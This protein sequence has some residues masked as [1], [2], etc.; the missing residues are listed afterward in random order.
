MKKNFALLALSFGLLC[1][2][3]NL[4]N[5]VAG[6]LQVDFD[7]TTPIA[8]NWDD[9][10]ATKTF[11]LTC[12]MPWMVVKDAAFPSWIEVSP[13]NDTGSATV[14]I[15]ITEDNPFTILR[16]A[17]ITFLSINNDKVEI[18]VTQEA[19]PVP[20][21]AIVFTTNDVVTSGLTASGT[22]S[23]V[24][25]Q[26]ESTAMT[27]TVTLSG[28]ATGTGTHTVG[29]TSTI[30]G[31][32]IGE[33]TPVTLDVTAGDVVLGETFDFTFTLPA[34]NVNDL[35]VVHTYVAMPITPTNVSTYVADLELN[36]RE[37]F[38]NL[39]NTFSGTLPVS[40]YKI[41]LGSTKVET[42]LANMRTELAP[43]YVDVV[44]IWG[45]TSSTSAEG[46]VRL[47]FRTTNSTGQY[48]RNLNLTS[49][50]TPPLTDAYFTGTTINSNTSYTYT[51]L[52]GN[53]NY[54]AFRVFFMASTGFTILQDGDVFWFRSI[55]DPNDWFKCEPYVLP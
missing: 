5:F 6:T 22:I 10:G 28:T 8:F 27:I 54:S 48:A 49:L 11:L 32:A 4:L 53:A 23:P 16:S 3:C 17:T 40:R 18:T 31:A 42:W 55:A 30:L 9:T 26:E 35:E 12:D 36:A 44:E 24:S 45:P 39:L 7:T 1:T 47:Q 21:Y 34:E 29:L 20:T 43:R 37:N 41:S 14:T 19:G 50:T 46:T 13:E 25:P 2:S 38:L 33:P 51:D 52:T 15:T